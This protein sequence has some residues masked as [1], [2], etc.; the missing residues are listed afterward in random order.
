MSLQNRQNYCTTVR[1]IKL[2][3]APLSQ[4]RIPFLKVMNIYE[5][6]ANEKLLEDKCL[7]PF[8]RKRFEAAALNSLETNI[9]KFL[10]QVN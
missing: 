8:V 1:T 7:S 6:K 9:S 5:I 2:L 10:P 3:F 4:E